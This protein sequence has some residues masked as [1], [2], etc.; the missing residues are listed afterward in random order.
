M[1]HLL[2]ACPLGQAAVGVVG[3]ATPILAKRFK[4]IDFSGAG[5]FAT[6]SLFKKCP[7]RPG[8]ALFSLFFAKTAE[9]FS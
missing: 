9:P 1:R 7:S 4:I 8:R 5:S 2:L 6:G 3:S